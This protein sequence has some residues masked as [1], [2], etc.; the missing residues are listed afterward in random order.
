M[1]IRTL[2]LLLPAIA[3]AAPLV[4]TLATSF[5]F[6]KVN[7]SRAKSII[8]GTDEDLAK[9]GRRGTDEDLAKFGRRG[10]DEDLAKFGRRG[11]DEDL[12]MQRHAQQ[13]RGLEADIEI[14]KFG[15]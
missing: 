11:T 15:K 7:R 2:L 12:G 5:V 9:F 10:T 14:A 3:A 1:Q 6:G 8:R 4:R 13:S